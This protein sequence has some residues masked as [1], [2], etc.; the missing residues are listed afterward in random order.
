MYSYAHPLRLSFCPFAHFPYIE[1]MKRNHTF[2]IVSLAAALLS[3]QAC[4][5]NAAPA[6]SRQTAQSGTPASTKSS[7][8][9]QKSPRMM[10]YAEFATILADTSVDT[11]IVDVRA[12]EEFN[13]GHIPGAV[14]FPYDEIEARKD[15]FAR[16]AGSTNRPIVVYCRSGRRSAIAAASLDKLGYTNIADFG[17][18][19]NWK[20]NI[21]STPAP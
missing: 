9:A 6:K 10:T 1:C 14:L 11:L 12:K 21:D 15:E 4:A 8:Q 18:L 20:G 17:G 3:I 7:G 19:G 16:L 13:E 5:N 2:I